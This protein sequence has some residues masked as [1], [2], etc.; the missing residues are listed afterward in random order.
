MLA[1]DLHR[2]GTEA[3]LRENAGY[4]GTDIKRNHQQIAPLRF[5]NASHRHAQ[6]QTG[7]RMQGGG[8][9]CLQ[10]DWHDRLTIGKRICGL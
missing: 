7:D 9:G 8:I 6:T 1:A 10:V 4:R 5:A 3:V 2:G